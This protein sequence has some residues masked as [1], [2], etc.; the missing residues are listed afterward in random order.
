[1]SL[2]QNRG[3]AAFLGAPVAAVPHSFGGVSV[4]ENTDVTTMLGADTFTDL[5][6]GTAILS[7]TSVGWILSDAVTGELTYQGP[8]VFSGLITCSVTFASIGGGAKTT[9]RVVRNG[10]SL[11]ED[12]ISSAQFGTSNLEISLVAPVIMSAGDTLRMQVK[13]STGGDGRI[14]NLSMQVSS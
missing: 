8:E 3:T 9:F 6:L 2:I 11:P 13:K 4:S 12:I 14:H 1:M 5:D 10:L 7:S